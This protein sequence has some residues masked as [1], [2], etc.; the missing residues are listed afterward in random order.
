MIPFET[1]EFIKIDAQGADFDV[2]QS[3]GKNLQ[4][5]NTI[6]VEVQTEPLYKNS[7]SEA[8]FIQYMEKQGFQVIDSLF[9][10]RHEINIMFHNKKY[11]FPKEKLPINLI[12]KPEHRI[13]FGNRGQPL[14]DINNF[15]I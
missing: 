6:V 7:V 4:R 13:K 11:S 2:V 8:E 15:T 9:Q 12:F 10:N 14:Q 1:V 3:A 5:I